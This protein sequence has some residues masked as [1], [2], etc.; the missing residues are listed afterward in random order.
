MFV[1][2]ITKVLSTSHAQ[3]TEIFLLSLP[4]L[5]PPSCCEIPPPPSVSIYF[6]PLRPHFRFL[7]G[8]CF[9]LQLNKKE[10]QS[11]TLSPLLKSICSPVNRSQG[12][13]P[14]L[15]VPLDTILSH[16]VCKQRFIIRLYT[17]LLLVFK[18]FQ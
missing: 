18:T 10:I 17:R 3:S 14:T 2:C 16:L 12:A 4:P 1:F 15:T 6:I 8:L 11:I 9:V 13:T 5:S 7:L